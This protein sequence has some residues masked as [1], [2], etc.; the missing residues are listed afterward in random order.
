M[1]CM[2]QICTS[3]S[4]GDPNTE[5]HGY[6]NKTRLR[7]HGFLGVLIP[8][9][10]STIRS[11]QEFDDVISRLYAD[12]LCR[13]S[14]ELG[15]ESLLSHHSRASRDIVAVISMLICQVNALRF[16]LGLSRSQWAYQ[17]TVKLRQMDTVQ[18]S[19]YSKP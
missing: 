18:T 6:A 17:P 7:F 1:N 5:I 2:D 13:I 15:T 8:H 4:H 3:N 12:D 10:Y 16:V 14:L 9:Y 11:T 19:T